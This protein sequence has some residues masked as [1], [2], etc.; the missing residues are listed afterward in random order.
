MRIQWTI[1]IIIFMNCLYAEDQKKDIELLHHSIQLQ[2]NKYFE[3]ETLYD[4][5]NVETNSFFAFWKDDIAR[6]NDKLIPTIKDTLVSF[7]DSEGFYKAKFEIEKNK[8]TVNIKIRENIP[9]KINKI[10]I[11]SDFPINQLVTLKKSHIFKAKEF[12]E[13]KSNI[14]KALLNEGYCSYALD[15]KAYVDLKRD[16]VDVKF[17]LKKGE[18]CTFG[19]TTIKGL[20]TIDKNIVS[21]RILAKKGKRY[22]PKKIKESY[23]KVFDLDAFDSIVLSTDRKFYNEVPVDLQLVELEKPYHYEIGA[24][25]DTFVGA[26][27]HGMIS[28]R[29]F[30]GNAQKITLRTSLSQREQLITLDYF[31]PVLF[32]LFDYGIDFGTNL[33]Y[34][35]LEYIGFREKKSFIKSYLESQEGRLNLKAGLAL[36]NIDISRVDNFK[37]NQGLVQAVKEG[38]F[39]LFY[40]FV[41]AVYD[42]RDS[43]LNPK[44][45]YYLSAYIEYG[46]PYSDS[47]SAYVKTLLEGRVIHTFG[48]LT[49][50]SVGK[51]GVVDI[52]ANDMPE[53]KL[54]FAGGSFFNRAYGFREIGVIGSS[55]VDSIEGGLSMLNLSF[56]AD[57]PIWGDL[58]GAIFSDN[59][60][61]TDKSY[62]FTGDY[63]HS[64]GVGVRY[65]TPIGPFKVDVGWN[66]NDT[67]QYGISFQIGQSF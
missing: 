48:D 43:K 54:L 63:I 47:A 21:S 41:N 61:L 16:S 62:D 3:K 34:S 6:I 37:N 46:L 32:T 10:E 60:M 24:G 35:N 26:R 25:Y 22:D 67:A 11:L 52:R 36:E 57:Y 9:V 17:V 20:K 27:V 30:L 28:K 2:G 38:N 45:G 59:T 65:M 56:E 33:G 58:Y 50:A 66:I 5:L 7:Y 29:N 55:T 19:E 8:T 15:A 44:Y 23:A 49:L 53:S 51:Y 1:L 31:K 42:A 18:L 4:I 13:I 40:P 64:A 14:A 39:L 12:V